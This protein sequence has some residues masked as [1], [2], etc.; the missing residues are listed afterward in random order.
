MAPSTRTFGRRIRDH[1]LFSVV[2][3][4]GLFLV[5]RLFGVRSTVSGL[6]LSILITLA[7]NVG[8]SYL[9]EARARRNA[10]SPRS[11][12]RGGGDIRWRD[13]DR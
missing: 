11:V 13:E 5:L 6:F 2:A 7:L 10:R 12:P 1:L 3:I 9:T 4:F 8:L